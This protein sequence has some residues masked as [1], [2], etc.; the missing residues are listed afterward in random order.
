MC[1]CWRGKEEKS[2]GVSEVEWKEELGRRRETGGGGDETRGRGKEGKRG[3]KV[4]RGRRE[5]G[6]R[7][8]GRRWAEKCQSSHQSCVEPD[9]SQLISLK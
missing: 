5:G 1:L 4:D 3:R 8:E 6:E 9:L 2:L 7:E